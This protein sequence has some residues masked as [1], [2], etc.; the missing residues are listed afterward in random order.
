ME[1][2]SPKVKKKSVRDV[3]KLDIEIA[4]E[5]EDRAIRETETFYDGFMLAVAMTKIIASGGKK[6]VKLDSLNKMVKKA[7]DRLFNS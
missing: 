7:F 3:C 4:K 2:K 6:N 1:I 5:M